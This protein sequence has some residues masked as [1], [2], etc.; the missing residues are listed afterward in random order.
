MIYDIRGYIYVY[1]YTPKSQIENPHEGILADN[2][3]YR[4]PLKA[5]E[6]AAKQQ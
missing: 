4:Q 5:S 6:S 1:T 3:F 2:P